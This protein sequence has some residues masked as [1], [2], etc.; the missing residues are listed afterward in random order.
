MSKWTLLPV[1]AVTNNHTSR[2]RN[3]VIVGTGNLR[4]T[5]SIHGY[6]ESNEDGSWSY[7]KFGVVDKNSTVAPEPEL[8]CTEPSMHESIERAINAE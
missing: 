1:R 8:V 6:V 3:Y 5:S 7:W 4:A 2:R